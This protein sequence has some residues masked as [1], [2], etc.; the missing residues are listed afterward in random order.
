MRTTKTL[1]LFFPLLLT[2]ACTSLGG[3]SAETGEI[4]RAEGPGAIF[5]SVE[6]A[7]FDALTYAH[8]LRFPGVR[9]RLIGGT[10]MR[11][12]SGYSYTTPIASRPGPGYRKPTVRYQMG[13][14]AVAHYNIYTKTGDFV[15]DRKNEQ[16][17]RRAKQVV[18]E[19]DPLHR[20]VYVLTPSLNVI[21]YDGE[22]TRSV[23]RLDAPR[24]R[25][26]AT[27]ER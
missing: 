1:T 3:R 12:E 26:I 7:V 9:P 22:R 13:R 23:A 24:P 6:D 18:D 5:S 15:L 10:I 11:V 14:E 16:P 8:T 25:R 27:T 2:L 17:S 21:R 4:R 19:M 20:P